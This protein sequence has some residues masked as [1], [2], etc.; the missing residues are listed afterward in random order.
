MSKSTNRE[1]NYRPRYPI[2]RACDLTGIKLLRIVKVNI[3][4]LILLMCMLTAICCSEVIEINSPIE[5]SHQNSSDLLDH[6]ILGKN[7]PSLNFGQVLTDPGDL[8]LTF[9]PWPITRS[10]QNESQPL[11]S[12]DLRPVTRISKSLYSSAVLPSARSS[13]E[14]QIIPV[15]QSPWDETPSIIVNRTDNYKTGTSVGLQQS[16]DH[17]RTLRRDRD[18]RRRN[19]AINHQY[20]NTGYGENPEDLDADYAPQENHYSP[21]TSYGTEYTDSYSPRFPDQVIDHI[22]GPEKYSSLS[23]GSGYRSNRYYE[24]SEESS[25]Y[26]GSPEPWHPH[27]HHH[28][29]PRPSLGYQKFPAYSSCDNPSHGEATP[30]LIGLLSA[31]GSNLLNLFKIG[32]GS[33]LSIAIPL[34]ALKFFLIPLKIFKFIKIAKILLKLFFV[35]PFILRVFAPSIYS[36]ITLHGVGFAERIAEVRTEENRG[37]VVDQPGDDSTWWNVLGVNLTESFLAEA[38]SAQNCPSRVA[39][40][41]GSYLASRNKLPDNLSN[42][43]LHANDSEAG[44]VSRNNAGNEK[45]ERE[46]VTNVFITALTQR[47]TYDRCNVYACGISL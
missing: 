16:L 15:R 29:H 24:N 13:D 30:S 37:I 14:R 40:E 41:L 44:K 26:P 34:I 19:D 1:I 23:T 33:S 12:D 18:R 21:S 45:K 10:T 31:I 3:M 25:S 5:A 17:R 36:A 46:E 38:T 7:P 42:F 28:H 27:H 9:V 39:C 35:I 11:N 22:H 47:W 4:L 32:L 8:N 20:P 2:L 43:L 6:V